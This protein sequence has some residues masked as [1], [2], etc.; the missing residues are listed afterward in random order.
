M[1][2]KPVYIVLLVLASVLLTGCKRDAEVNAA[3]AEVDAFTN[4]MVGRIKAAPNPTIGVD[5]AQA[6][7]DSRKREI[8]AKAAYLAR[9][10]GIQVTGETEKK[11]IETVRLD[12][13]TV[14]SLQSSSQ[15]MNLTMSNAA[16]KTKLDKLVNDY[17]DLFQA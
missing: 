14:V 11:L 10:R 13:M 3:L 8:K 9:V 5:D 12:Q 15:F 7:L 17:L 4:E 6:Y 2:G 1:T 16:F